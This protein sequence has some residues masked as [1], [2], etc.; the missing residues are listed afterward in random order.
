MSTRFEDLLLMGAKVILVIAVVAFAVTSFVTT[1]K[2]FQSFLP[3]E[4]ALIAALGLQLTLTATEIFYAQ[5]KTTRGRIVALATFLFVIPLAVTFSYIGLREI[6]AKH[7][8]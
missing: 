4:V 2:G 5:V 7:L 3:Y 1:F 6:F 8:A